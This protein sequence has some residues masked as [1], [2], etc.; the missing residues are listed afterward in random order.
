MFSEA[1]HYIIFFA[2]SIVS[3]SVVTANTTRG[4]W[5]CAQ[6]QQMSSRFP[7]L[8]VIGFADGDIHVGTM[9]SMKTVVYPEGCVQKG[10][11]GRQAGKP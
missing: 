4:D 6:V 8:N 10:S 1:G 7:Q 5:L 11:E 3:L 2:L 9:T